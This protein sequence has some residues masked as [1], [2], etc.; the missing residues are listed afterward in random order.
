ML[1]NVKIPSP[2]R[3]FAVGML[4][5][6]VYTFGSVAAERVGRNPTHR[7]PQSTQSAR[8]GGSQALTLH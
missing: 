2:R 7:G 1:P 4:P 6:T 3:A 8:G 5:K